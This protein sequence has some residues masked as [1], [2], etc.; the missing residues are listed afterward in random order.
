[1]HNDVPAIEVPWSEEYRDFVQ[2]ALIRDDEKRPDAEAL[3]KHPFL[4]DA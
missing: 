3:L 1:V 2:T 4:S